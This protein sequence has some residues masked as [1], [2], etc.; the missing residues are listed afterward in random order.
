[1]VMKVNLMNHLQTSLL[2]K[3]KKYIIIVID[4]G[5]CITYLHYVVVFLFLLRSKITQ[6]S[7]FVDVFGWRI[8]Y[9]YHTLYLKISI[10]NL[11]QPYTVNLKLIKNILNGHGLV[12]EIHVRFDLLED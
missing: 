1:M 5:L 3:F 8:F 11:M 4:T 6:L 12:E 9:F 10:I 2:P 7:L